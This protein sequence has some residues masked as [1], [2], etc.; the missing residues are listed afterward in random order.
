MLKLSPQAG[1]LLRG[2]VLLIG[3]LTLWWFVLLDPMLFWLRTAANLM[4]TI[5]ERASGEWTVRVPLNAALAPTAEYPQG[6]QIHS[7]D[8][9]LARADSI[10]FTFSLPVF[11]AV[12][13]AAPGPVRQRLRPVLLGTIL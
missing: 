11:W 12:I 1:F 9:D 4:V 7:V 13:L 6:Q 5:E 3:L 2:S 10:A 8:F